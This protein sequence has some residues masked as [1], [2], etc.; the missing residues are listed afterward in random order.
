LER[1]L[2]GVRALPGVQNAGLTGGLP[3]TSKGGLREEV[4]PEGGASG[5]NQVSASVIYR[6]ITP[7]FFETMKIPLIRGRLFDSSDREETPPVVVI[8]QK[9]AQDFWP[10][11]YPIGKRL[12]FGRPGSNSPWLQVVGV[13]G[14]VKQV[15]LNEPDRQEVYCPYLQSRATWEWSRFLVL[16]TTGDPLRA[17]AQLRELVT[18]IDP[19]EPLNHVMTMSDIVER[20]T[21]QTK[22]QAALLAGLAVLALTMACV[23][24]YGVMAFLVA[25]RL[26]EIGVRMALGAQ[27][28]NILRLVLGHGTKLALAGVAIGIVSAVLAGKLISTLLFGVSAV[29]PL[30]FSGVS[31]LLTFVALVACYIPARR[32]MRVDPMVALRHE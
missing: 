21:A 24:I 31:I 15:G 1:V 3:L 9:A 16:R 18:G 12:K 17:Q 5:F 10:G 25:Q 6:V 23:G 32:A 30:T 28:R 20:E 22:M 11:Q 8:N 26:Q 27:P 14:N 2:E 7:G 19:Q 29:D 13:T 4:T